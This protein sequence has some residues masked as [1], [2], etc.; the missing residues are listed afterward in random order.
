MATKAELEVENEELRT[1]LND[2]E[3]IASNTKAEIL[4]VLSEH[5]AIIAK[6]RHEIG[7]QAMSES[8]KEHL[9]GHYQRVSEDI[10]II[11]T[12]IK[13]T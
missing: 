10:D 4:S 8:T 13:E 9:K 3:S 6:K 2:A 1:K 11:M 5:K 12:Q 7:T